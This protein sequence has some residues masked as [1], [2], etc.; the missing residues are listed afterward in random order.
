MMPNELVAQ[1]DQAAT[2]QD[3]S[4]AWLIRAAVKAYLAPSIKPVTSAAEM[5][6]TQHGFMPQPGNALRCVC[7]VRKG[8]HK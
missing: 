4:R 1:I 2:E 3:R 8:D 6:A 5:A 7:G